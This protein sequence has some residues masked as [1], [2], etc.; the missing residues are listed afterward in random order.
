M[1]IGRLLKDSHEGRG[2]YRELAPFPT[3]RP[4]VLVWK[5]LKIL[6]APSRVLRSD[7]RMGNEAARGL[8]EV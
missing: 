5:R 8:R 1:I 7:V 2:I 6:W 4:L 3:L